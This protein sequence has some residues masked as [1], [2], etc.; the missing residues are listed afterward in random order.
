MAQLDVLL[1]RLRYPRATIVMDYLV[2]LSGHRQGPGAPSRVFGRVLALA[3]DAALRCSDIVVVDTEEHLVDLP[4][5]HR[6]KG[7]VV[8]VGAPAATFAGRPPQLP[9][10]PPLRVLF[11]GRY[12]PLQGTPT[13]GAAIGALHDRGP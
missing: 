5:R 13:I 2:S 9:A 1:A 3:D 12:I 8:L 11:C 7:V 10:A 4:E 6:S